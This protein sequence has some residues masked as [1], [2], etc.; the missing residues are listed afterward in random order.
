MQLWRSAERTA[1]GTPDAL[2]IAMQIFRSAA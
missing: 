1:G 2:T